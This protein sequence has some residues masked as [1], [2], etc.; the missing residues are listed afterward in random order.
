M[1]QILRA[2]T[3]TPLPAKYTATRPKP[4]EPEEEETKELP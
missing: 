2:P 1:D 3:M 4:P